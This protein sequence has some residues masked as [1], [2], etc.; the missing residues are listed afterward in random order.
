MSKIKDIISVSKIVLT[1]VT[2]VSFPL[3]TMVNLLLIDEIVEFWKIFVTT[4]PLTLGIMILA[5]S[6]LR[7]GT[8]GGNQIL[9]FGLM[10]AA[11]NLLGY[12]TGLPGLE[13]IFNESSGVFVSIA[14]ILVGY[15]LTYGL[16]TIFSSLIIGI[17][18]GWMWYRFKD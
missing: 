5:Y 10:L 6:Y 3:D 4:T 12:A 15:I 11:G 17:F 9:I 13:D 2:L 1:A 8:I 16:K 14:Y 18:L 7:D